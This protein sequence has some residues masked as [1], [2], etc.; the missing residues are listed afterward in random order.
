MLDSDG[1]Y[2]FCKLNSDPQIHNEKGQV[3]INDLNVP[4]SLPSL[5]ANL[6]GI[7]VIKLICYGD[8]IV[9]LSENP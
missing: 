1:I 3:F 8:R 9:V 7:K 5:V 4:E 6:Q 2:S